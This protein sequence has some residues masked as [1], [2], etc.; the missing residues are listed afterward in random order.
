MLV[1]SLATSL[2]KVH[3]HEEFTGI[4]VEVCTSFSLVSGVFSAAVLLRTFV[5]LLK[6]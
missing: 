4:D 6:D 5:M 3:W 1:I 2:S